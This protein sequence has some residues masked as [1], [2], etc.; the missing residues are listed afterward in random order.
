[1]DERKPLFAGVR[2]MIN[3]GLDKLRFPNAV[4]SGSRVRAHCVLL[5]VEEV[6]GGLQITEQYTVE[7]SGEAKPAC[8]AEAIMRAY[9]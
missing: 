9:F 3:Y 7:I 2:Q 4:K 5:K 1:V 8:V 6:T